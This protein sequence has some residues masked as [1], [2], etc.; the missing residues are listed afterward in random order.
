MKQNGLIESIII[1]HFEGYIHAMQ[2]QKKKIP[3]NIFN[4]WGRKRWQTKNIGCTRS[5][6]KTSTTFTVLKSVRKC[7]LSMR[8][9]AWLEWSWIELKKR[10]PINEADYIETNGSKEVEVKNKTATNLKHNPPDIMLD[11]KAMTCSV[12]EI[13]CLLDTNLVRKVQEKD[14]N[15][16]PLIRSLKIQ[17]PL[18]LEQH[19]ISV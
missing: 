8:H 19:T 17:Y 2:K 14:D 13:S 18:L 10:P 7:L 5:T 1:S 11:H 9:D 12:V 3:L 16:G 6:L 4:I 15:H